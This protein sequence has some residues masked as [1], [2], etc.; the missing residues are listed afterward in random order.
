M[1]IPRSARSARSARSCRVL[2][3]G[4]SCSSADNKSYPAGYWDDDIRRHAEQIQVKHSSTQLT[5]KQLEDHRN[6]ILGYAT[7]ALNCFN[8]TSPQKYKLLKVVH[9]ECGPMLKYGLYHMN[10]SAKPTD[11]AAA[12]EEMFFTELT[13]SLPTGLSVKLCV[14]LGPVNSISGEK[15]NGCR[16]CGYMKKGKIWHP[17]GGGFVRGADSYYKTVKD[18]CDVNQNN[19]IPDCEKHLPV[20]EQVSQSGEPEKEHEYMSEQVDDA[21]LYATEALKF[22]NQQHHINYELVDPGFGTRVILPTCSLFHVNF[23]AKDTDPSAP[24]ELF[25]AELTSTSGVCSITHLSPP[26]LKSGDE[27]G[28]KTNGCYYCHEFNKV[29]HPGL[30]GFVRGGDSLYTSVKEFFPQL[31]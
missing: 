8:Q 31:T 7:Q 18:I 5:G 6:K 10:F 17:K 12:P 13:V 19:A 30:G 21:I 24:E 1:V 22:Y 3:W 9:F 11:V 27:T 28:D 14:S 25:F 26:D 16:F 23:K 29:H 2:G 4:G 15:L 20:L